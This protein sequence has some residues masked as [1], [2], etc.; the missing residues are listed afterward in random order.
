MSARTGDEAPAA[1]A[2]GG[3]ITLH[4]A[5]GRPPLFLV[6]PSGGSVTGYVRLAGLLGDDQPVHAIE[7]PALRRAEPAGDLAARAVDYVE[8]IRRVQPHGAYHLGGW[9]L[10]GVIALEMARQL[11]DAGH[12]VGAVVLLDPGLPTGPRPPDDLF[13]LSSF[14]GDLAGLAGV[15][16]PGID[17]RAVRGLDREALEEFTLDVLD[18]AGL[19]P[20]GLHDEVRMRMRAFGT[21]VRALHTHRP[22]PY[23]GPVTLIR[24]ADGPD[25]DSATWRALCPRLDRRTV[26]GD[27]YTMLRPPHLAALATAVRE[28]LRGPVPAPDGTTPTPPGS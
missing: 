12:P 9:S 24:T 4:R 3:V 2:D 14:V 27:H 25:T 22:R 6:H 26:P 21:N 1:L 20:A 7:D 28:A 11:A 8:L 16:P 18:R 13:T 23:H 5:T 17:P 10:G 19:V 15:A